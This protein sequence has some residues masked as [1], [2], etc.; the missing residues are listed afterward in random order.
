MIDDWLDWVL[1]DRLGGDCLGEDSIVI[2]VC[3]A[4]IDIKEWDGGRFNDGDWFTIGK[5]WC[6]FLVQRAASD[7]HFE[8][9]VLRW[10]HC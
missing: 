2:V 8:R 3:L 10:R 9:L 4:I 1:E 7:E 5:A 6:F